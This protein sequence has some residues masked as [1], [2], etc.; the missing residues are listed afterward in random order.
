MSFIRTLSPKV[1]DAA[2]IKAE[3]GLLLSQD[4]AHAR[5]FRIGRA[6]FLTGA[7]SVAAFTLTVITVA[8]GTAR[9]I[10]ERVRRRFLQARSPVLD[11]LSAVVTPLTSPAALITCSLA[12]AF[13]FRQLGKKVWLP[14]VSAPA[15]AMIAGRCFTAT[16][17]QQFAPTGSDG[18]PEVSFPSGHTT[19]ATAEALTIGYVLWRDQVVGGAA[20]GAMSLVPLLGAINR[21]YRDRHWSSDVAAGLTAGVAIATILAT[22][23][24][25]LRARD[26]IAVP[27]TDAGR[28]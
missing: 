6:L 13:R 7:A 18:E 26:A 15:L 10:D 11:A 21:L 4:V 3:Q 22:L 2:K 1:D 5:Q 24:E 19:G 20:A 8:T 16:L 25:K 28:P 23:G 12:T 27:I 9:P 17:P 14:I